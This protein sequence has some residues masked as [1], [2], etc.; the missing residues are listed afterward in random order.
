LYSH[1][2]FSAQR[3]C[4]D[5]TIVDG[6]FIMEN[7]VLL[8]VDESEILTQANYQFQKIAARIERGSERLG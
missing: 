6:R 5:S 3:G 8:T 1:L 2:V 7:R 4:V